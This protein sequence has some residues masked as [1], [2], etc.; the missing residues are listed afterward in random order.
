MKSNK[1]QVFLV[2]LTLLFSCP[3]LPSFGKSKSIEIFSQH[4]ILDVKRNIAK[5]T[6]QVMLSQGSMRI[7]AVRAEVYHPKSEPGVTLVNIYGDPIT[8][9]LAQ[10]DGS[11]IEGRASEIHYNSL[12]ELL[13]FKN[14]VRVKYLSNVLA[15]SRASYLI[16]QGKIQFYGDHEKHITAKAELVIP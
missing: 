6:G 1:L 8:F 15:G 4:Q 9:S 10:K 14:D 2:A 12:T 3:A 16:P 11:F 13:Q 5:F 7:L